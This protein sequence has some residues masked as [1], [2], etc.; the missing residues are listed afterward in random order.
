[1]YEEGRIFRMQQ[2][3]VVEQV[4]LSGCKTDCKCMVY[5]LL[6]EK[7]VN[8]QQTDGF[9]ILRWLPGIKMD[10]F[11]ITESTSIITPEAG[12]RYVYKSLH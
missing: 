6:Q 12:C 7:V 4:I 10:F 11:F 2:S 9:H 5:I 1:M 8:G 3:L